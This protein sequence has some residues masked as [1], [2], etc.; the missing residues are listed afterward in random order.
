M[1]NTP[2]GGK[3]QPHGFGILHNTKTNIVH[4]GSFSNGTEF[5]QQ[6]MIKYEPQESQY[7]TQLTSVNGVLQGPA[8]VERATGMVEVGSYEQNKR[9]GVWRFRRPDGQPAMTRIFEHG[10][11]VDNSDGAK[12]VTYTGSGSSRT[13]TEFSNRHPKA[14]TRV[15]AKTISRSKLSAKS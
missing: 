7:F 9:H 5:G 12:A 10:K 4:F 8:L 15:E 1:H 3:F 11:V 14:V 6:R 13:G 2:E